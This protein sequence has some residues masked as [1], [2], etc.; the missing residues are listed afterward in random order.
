VVEKLSTYK[1]KRDFALTAEP[2]G[3]A[4]VAPSQRLR[5]VIQKHAATRLHYDFRLEWEGVFKSWAVT[6]GPSL[7]PADKRLAVEVE[8]HPLDYGDF[9]GTIPK[10]Q[11]GGG[12]VMLWDRGYWAP[13]PGTTVE[14]G[15]AKGDLKIVLEGERLHG[16]WVLVRIKND[17]T[18][19][20][21][22]NWL[23]IKHKDGFV[24][25]G[26][27]DAL[28]EANDGSVASGRTMA[29]IAAGDGA[30]PT[31]FMTAGFGK[32]K[33]AAAKRV[34][35]SNRDDKTLSIE[36]A[37]EP[38]T[39]PEPSPAPKRKVSRFVKLTH[40]PPVQGSAALPAFVEP[41]LA[42]LADR[43]PPGAEWAHEIKFDGYRM[44]LRVEGGRATLLSRRGLDWTEKFPEIAAECAVLPDCMLDGEIVALDAEGAPDF[45]GLQAALSFTKT[46]ELV[47]F[48]FDALFAGG[49]DLR[50]QPLT[51]RKAR[52]KTV[53]DQ[54]PEAER[55]RFV[56]HFETGGEAVLQSACRMH[57]E[58][59]VSKR[60]DASYVSGRSDSWIKAKCR[61]GQE[62]I[63][64]G[65]V[66]NADGGFRSLIAGV[67]R[68]GR[69]VHVGRIGTGYGQGKVAV[70]LPRL[71]AV[72]APGS[73]FSG[74]GAPRSTPDVHWVRPVLVAEVESAG[75]TGD[76]H[77][78]QASFKGLR[79][80]KPAEE[81]VQETPEPV[82]ELDGAP[83]P[84]RL[85]SR[86]G[87]TAP[88][89]DKGHKRHST[90][91]T[92]SRGGGVVLGVTISNP[93]KPLWPAYN[94]EPAITK[95]DLARYLEAVDEHLMPH[96]VGRPCSIIRTPDGIEG[97][98]FFQRHAMPGTSSLLTLVTVSGDRKPYLQ[99]DRVEGLA[100]VA[101][102]GGVELHPWNCAPGAPDVPGR[103]VFDLDPAPDVPFAAVI[104]A[105]K[106][107]RERLERVGLVGFPKTTGGKG[108][109]V[110]TP[111][112]PDPHGPDW[113]AAKAFART[114]CER[115]AADGPTKY[116][117]T[118][119]KKDRTGRIFLDYLRN[120][121]LSTA[122][123]PYSPRA[124]PGAPVSW[125]LTWPQV[126]AGLDPSRFT[127]RTVPGLLAKSRAWADYAERARPLAPAIIMV[128]GKRAA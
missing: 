113:P 104:A 74:P 119:A 9:E 83:V 3:E 13:E 19:G 30:G 51:A 105:A 101:Q 79:E 89:R 44:Q 76:G 110:T 118:M 46:G 107:V 84:A 96:I 40:G 69:L 66:S 42:R 38:E 33:R 28:L 32:P 4:P 34:W 50:E 11:Y 114:L 16:G 17:R 47:F 117:T 93:A 60:L 91:T 5:Y 116:L 58:G 71:E 22:T 12:T 36:A 2:S 111:L 53:L 62:V 10:G 37:L 112:A 25:A 80:D 97:Q 14:Q 55:L 127:I 85:E 26:D 6:R 87:D 65:W 82:A 92:N 75:W 49:E 73:P 122:V 23:L 125:P 21:R 35:N 52:L 78:R 109:H 24:Q 103:L 31:P 86:Q 70:L 64:C 54:W 45:A 128:N 29:Q 1:Q 120:D 39:T 15:L 43:P 57:L 121:R 72:A 67:Q 18:G 102:T 81:V 115:M 63:V 126:K 90:A 108:L 61:G 59:V 68:D 7:D 20:K 99:V 123:A 106:E 124:R 88:E 100:A 95:L 77:L 27:H 98:T 94:G 8:D 56:E 48:L 41:Q